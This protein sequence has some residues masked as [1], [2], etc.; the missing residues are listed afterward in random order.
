VAK[1]PILRYGLKYSEEA[2]FGWQVGP[3]IAIRGIGLLKTASPAAE[4]P[5]K[6][7]KKACCVGFSLPRRADA[8]QFTEDQASI[9]PGHMN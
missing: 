6:K 5:E 1:V 8:Q 7:P 3:R 4:Q 9:E 2:A